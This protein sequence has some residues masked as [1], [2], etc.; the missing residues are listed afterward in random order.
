MDTKYDYSNIDELVC[1]DYSASC[2]QYERYEQRS[3]VDDYNKKDVVEDD[4]NDIFS[5]KKKITKITKKE[6]FCAGCVIT[7]N[8]NTFSK[9][10]FIVNEKIVIGCDTNKN[11]HISGSYFDITTKLLYA[12]NYGRIIEINIKKYYEDGYQ[13]GSS[14]TNQEYVTLDTWI[15]PEIIVNIN[16]LIDN[17]A[18]FS[19]DALEKLFTQQME[20]RNILKNTIPQKLEYDEKLLKI[21]ERDDRLKEDKNKFD[22]KLK[23]FELEKAKFYDKQ[24]LFE[25]EKKDY[26]EK[27]KTMFDL[28]SDRKKL[29]SE[30]NE[31]NKFKE[32]LKLMAK[33]LKLKELEIEK[34]FNILNSV[35]IDGI[36]I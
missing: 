28:I 27:E 21:N 32:K 7:D 2:T 10:R 15:A 34:Q 12:T 6:D 4:D 5:N 26:L 29:E 8:I 14:I 17:G 18:Y 33:K 20:N 35:K 25:E 31:V 30:K 3:C 1:C 13:S 24:K 11:D 23:Q 19:C 36:D 16:D 9:K 22:E